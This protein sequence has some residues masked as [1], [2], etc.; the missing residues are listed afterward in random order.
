MFQPD[1]LTT[2]LTLPAIALAML[3]SSVIGSA[4]TQFVQWFIQR[5]HITSTAAENKIQ[6]E[7]A[8]RREIYF[9]G[10]EALG[11]IQT[12][13]FAHA[14]VLSSDE[15]INT[16]VRNVRGILNKVALI[17]SLEVLTELDKAMSHYGRSVR[18]LI[19][20]RVAVRMFGQQLEIDEKLHAEKRQALMT[21][22][23]DI[24]ASN[25]PED[26]IRSLVEQ[27]EAFRNEYDNEGQALE[28]RR[29]K[30][31]DDV[32]DLTTTAA[33][34]A[35]EFDEHA[36]P[37]NVIVR[38]ELGFE[39][40]EKEYGKLIADATVREK[41][42]GQQWVRDYLESHRESAVSTPFS[43]DQGSESKDSGQTNKE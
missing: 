2:N 5:R 42:E 28:S 38:K 37:L 34:L 29:A 3:T 21:M 16:P 36:A 6:R 17:G 43:F 23:S 20:R 12:H 1:T 8:I 15:Q 9:E 25:Q 24:M 19:A 35:L 33:Q 22:G 18:T 26:Q 41:Q 11:R 10:A 27:F 32:G 39:I 30:V 7:M 31:L 13:I 4:L 40:D 14:D